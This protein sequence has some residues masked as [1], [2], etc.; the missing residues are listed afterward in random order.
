VQ[1]FQRPS[2]DLSKAERKNLYG[3]LQKRR[4]DRRGSKVDQQIGATSWLSSQQEQ[5]RQRQA[6]PGY[7]GLACGYDQ[8]V[9]Q[10]RRSPC[11]DV[12]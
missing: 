4:D 1:I 9:E 6:L 5:L 11:K 7:Q 8:K 3:S 10:S 2:V 12:D